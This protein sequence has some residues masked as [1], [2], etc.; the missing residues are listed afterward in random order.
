MSLSNT[1]FLFG[2]IITDQYC[3]NQNI[4]E[5]ACP[6][7]SNLVDVCSV[8]DK[9]LAWPRQEKHSQFDHCKCWLGCKKWQSLHLGCFPHIQVEELSSTRTNLVLRLQWR[10]PSETVL[11]T[12][13]V[14]ECHFSPFLRWPLMLAYRY[15]K[16]PHWHLSQC[17][18]LWTLHPRLFQSQT[19]MCFCHNCQGST[20]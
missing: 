14:V 4:R 10:T 18:L 3:W 2:E 20:G 8:N 19:W 7:V 13:V 5:I 6:S 11:L 12:V 16:Q 9:S 15:S 1:F 17:L